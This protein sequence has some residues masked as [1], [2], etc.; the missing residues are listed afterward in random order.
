MQE[1]GNKTFS[2]KNTL[3]SDMDNI[4]L[5]TSSLSIRYNSD[6]FSLYACDAQNNI[7]LR[8]NSKVSN[9]ENRIES[10]GEFLEDALE[11]NTN[12]Q[13]TE[14]R[15]QSEH[16]IVAPSGLFNLNELLNIIEFQHNSLPET[17]FTLQLNEFKEHNFALAFIIDTNIYDVICS[18]FDD[19]IIKHHLTN[20]IE[21]AL[22]KE[23][24]IRCIVRRNKLDLILAVKNK[25]LYCNSHTYTTNED[26]LYHLLN[27]LQTLNIETDNRSTVVSVE[28]EQ[29]GLEQLLREHI[30]EL[31]FKT[32]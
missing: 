2:V 29:Q 23:T 27:M 1:I 6:G 20:A 21:D 15:I 7:T 3:Y 32:R 17:E 11:I 12:T 28:F 4:T 22:T 9:F 30:K 10:F 26:I 25:L 24:A 8:K 19:F 16:Y 31:E 13:H 5:S 14:F 18:K